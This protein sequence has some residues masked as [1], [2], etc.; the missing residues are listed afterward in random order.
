MMLEWNARPQ[1][2]ICCQREA[3]VSCDGKARITLD[4][5]ICVSELSDNLLASRMN[6][7]VICEDRAVLLEL[8]FTERFPNW[9]MDMVRT[10]N[11][12]EDFHSKHINETILLAGLRLA[13]ADLIYNIVL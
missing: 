1:L 7:P 8:R 12:S 3:Y 9:C 13:L 11:L 2:H 5:G 6:N 4:R 10:F